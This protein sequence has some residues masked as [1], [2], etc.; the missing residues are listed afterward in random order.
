MEYRDEKR[1]VLVDMACPRE[2]TVEA[3]E[4][5]KKMK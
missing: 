3:K 2:E 4:Q 5:V 1:I